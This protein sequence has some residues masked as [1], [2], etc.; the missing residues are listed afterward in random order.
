MLLNP[1]RMFIDPNLPQNLP[2]VT[3]KC[4]DNSHISRSA[5]ILAT[6]G[7]MLSAFRICLVG[8]PGKCEN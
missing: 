1:L 6:Q 4:R 8:M 7:H 5:A 3:S 2:D